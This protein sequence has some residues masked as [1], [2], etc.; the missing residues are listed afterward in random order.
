MVEFA[1]SAF[2]SY[3]V[4]VDPVGLAP[5]FLSITASRSRTEQ[6]RI[7]RN[8]VL[9]ATLIIVLFGVGG[10]SLLEYLGVSIDALRIAGGILLFKLAFD[11]I[12][13]HRER[14]TDVERN[15]AEV[16]ED[17]TVFPLAIPLLAGPG[18]F[19]T[20]LVFVAR[21]DGR[22]EYLAILLGCVVLVMLLA[23]VAL[24]M[25]SRVTAVLGFTGI[26][27]ITRVFGIILAALAVQLVADGAL[28]LWR[29]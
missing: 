14:T 19:A 1:V 20:V 25:A 8:S 2:L 5:L 26:N 6:H 9:I 10:R 11:M 7:A 15:E 23:W 21:A 28:A 24:R 17:V 12:L 4:I 27:V 18:A 13:G 3:L 16:R 29:A 22:P